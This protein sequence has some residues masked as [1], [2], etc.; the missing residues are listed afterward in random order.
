MWRPI[1]KEIHKP[2]GRERVAQIPQEWITKDI[3]DGNSEE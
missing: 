3:F 1:G 2:T